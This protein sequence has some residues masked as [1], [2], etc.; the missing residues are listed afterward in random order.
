VGGTRSF[1]REDRREV[2]V[3]DPGEPS[4]A[5]GL[6]ARLGGDHEDRLAAIDDL[7]GGEHGL[8][9][10]GVDRRDVDRCVRVATGQHEHHARCGAH[11]IQLERDDPGPGPLRKAEGQVQAAFGL[12][13]VVDVEGPAGDVGLGRIVGDRRVHVA[14]CRQPLSSTRSST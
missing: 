9:V 2:L 12:D 11:R 6:L 3:D 8:F 14:G 10:A 13:E 5:S 4:G 7:V 1:D